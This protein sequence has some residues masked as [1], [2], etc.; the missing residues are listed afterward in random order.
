MTTSVLSAQAQTASE[1]GCLTHLTPECQER[2]GGSRAFLQNDIHLVWPPKART[3]PER[4]K[5]PTAPRPHGPTAWPPAK[6]DSGDA[7][8]PQLC[9]SPEPA[10]LRLKANTKT[11]RPSCPS[12]GG[13]ALARGGAGRGAPGRPT[14]KRGALRTRAV[15][16]AARYHI[17]RGRGSPEGAGKQGLKSERGEHT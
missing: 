5:G 13:P 2:D 9:L 4:D 17:L 8:V 11:G 16:A 14:G 12:R 3:R 7:D 6:P 1:Q 15:A 10:S